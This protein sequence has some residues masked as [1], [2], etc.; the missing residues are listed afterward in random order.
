LPKQITTTNV[1]SNIEQQHNTS[2]NS[3]NEQ[4]NISFIAGEFIGLLIGC[5]SCSGINS[6]LGII[7]QKYILQEKKGE[8]YE[9]ESNEMNSV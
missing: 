5:H 4:K 9:K 1:T 6:F 2:S 3:N 8:K 7:I